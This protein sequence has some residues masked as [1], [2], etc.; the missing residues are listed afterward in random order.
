MSSPDVPRL[1]TTND[2]VT[3]THHRLPVATTWFK[4]TSIANGLDVITEPYVHA[5]L[6]AN[7]WHLRGRDRDLIVDTGLGGLVRWTA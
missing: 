2:S 1:P 6:Q 7:I 5:F 4:T 3:T